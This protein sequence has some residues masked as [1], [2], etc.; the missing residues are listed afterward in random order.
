MPSNRCESD[1]SPSPDDDFDALMARIRA[2]D[3]AA[4][5]LVFRRFVD[6][7]IALASRRFDAWMR[8][9]ADVEEV[10]LSAYKSFFIR[11]GRGDFDLAGWDELWALLAYIT[12]R[13]CG[14]RQRFARA[15]RRDAAREVSLTKGNAGLAW[16]PDRTPTPLET[17]TL[18]ETVELLFQAMK[19]DE[20]PIV[21]QILMGCNSEEIANRCDCS[22]RTVV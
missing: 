7:L 10:V 1:L 3:D 17:A 5:T 22:V 9:R 13:K 2:G 4:E 20:R 16:L 21:E 18:N 8:D 12:L 19:P 11:N 14:K 15:A 6:R